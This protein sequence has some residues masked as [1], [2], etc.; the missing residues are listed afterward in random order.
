MT[1]R[2]CAA[3][4]P[5]EQPAH[6]RERAFL[7][8][9]ADA[10]AIALQRL[11]VDEVHADEPAAIVLGDVVDAHDVRARHLPREQELAAEPLERAGTAREL[12]PQQFQRDV[13]VEREI[14]GAVD[15]AHAADA[16]QP[17]DAEAAA[18]QLADAQLARRDLAGQRGGAGR[19]G[20]GALDRGVMGHGAD[21][22]A[23]R[24]HADSR[25]RR[26]PRRVRD[27]AAS[28]QLPTGFAGGRRSFQSGA[29]TPASAAERTMSA[30]SRSS[31]AASNAAA[32]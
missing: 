2:V 3:D 32:A 18:E 7:R 6:D 24:C 25:A 5:V 22:S 11:A 28:G 10:V 23:S 26:S 16:E 29:R 12:G 17:I 14:A 20:P 1:P 4:E 9:L 15:D 31:R 8:N 21:D 27:A 13:D 30:T 19:R